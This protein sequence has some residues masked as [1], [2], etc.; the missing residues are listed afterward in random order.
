MQRFHFKQKNICIMPSSTPIQPI[1]D[2][3]AALQ[4]TLA[5]PSCAPHEPFV[6]LPPSGTAPV[7]NYN[8]PQ[9]TCFTSTGRIAK[10]IPVE[11]FQEFTKNVPANNYYDTISKM[12]AAQLTTF[13][14]PNVGT[15]T[16]QYFIQTHGAAFQAVQAAPNVA[17]NVGAMAPISAHLTPTPGGEVVATSLPFAGTGVAGPAAGAPPSPVPAGI[18][19]SMPVVTAPSSAPS[20]GRYADMAQLGLRPYAGTALANRVDVARY[21]A[22]PFR[23]VPRIAIIEE[24][25]TCSYLGDYGAGKVVK[26]MSLLPGERTTISIRTYSDR[27]TTAGYSDN[28]LDSFSDSSAMELD[29][30]VQHESGSAS[31]DNETDGSHNSSY[32]ASTDAKNSSSSFNLNV[33]GGI[34]LKIFSLHA[35]G[36]YGRSESEMSTSSGG[37]SS[38]ADYSHSGMRT[39]NVS[40]LDNAMAKHVAQSNANRQVDVNHTTTSTASSGE[41]DVTVRELVNVNKSRVLNFVWRQMLQEYTTISSLV[42]LKFAYTNG[43]PESLTIVPLGNLL[44]MLTDII[45]PEH[46]NDVLC[47]LLKNYCKVPNWNDDD[48]E[49]I[50]RIDRA[51]EATCLALGAEGVCSMTES[52][53]RK[54]RGLVDTYENATHTLTV[55]VNGVILSVKNYTLHTDSLV[56]DAVLGQ[57][58][59]L[60][61]FNQKAQDAE[62]QRI[63]INNLATSQSILANIQETANELSILNNQI[64]TINGITDPVQKATLYKKIF[65]DC[66]DVPQ[67]CCGGCGE[68]VAP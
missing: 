43:Y 47:I 36:G 15:N 17:A 1:L 66:C 59:A 5:Q 61:C 51:V 8:I 33:S 41:E 11:Y 21:V 60:D 19:V 52:Y 6:K 45:V 3:L 57:G 48:I 50:E 25:R 4:A 54:K 14:H 62:T 56:C 26:T 22:K 10:Y 49:F 40:N 58:E 42:N 38:T 68:P 35:G 30:L 12:T 20:P 63:Y 13:F 32:S 2:S 34:D 44:N 67:S 46:I 29:N 65:G 16:L 23:P 53:Y 31:A 39:A 55:D 28:V 24:Y 64:A 7:L 27:S 9:E 37:E 18:P